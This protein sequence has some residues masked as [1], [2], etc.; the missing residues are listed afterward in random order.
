MC[1]KDIFNLIVSTKDG[2]A[3]YRNWYGLLKKVILGEHIHILA[4]AC[5][6]TAAGEKKITKFMEDIKH[7]RGQV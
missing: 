7:L 4:H 5:I 3:A 6:H 2:S 1:R